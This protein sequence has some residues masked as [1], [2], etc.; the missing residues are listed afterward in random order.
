MKA[1][2]AP[3]KPDHRFCHVSVSLSVV[4]RTL[5]LISRMSTKPFSCLPATKSQIKLN[6]T[7]ETLGHTKYLSVRLKSPVRSLKR[8][9]EE[10]TIF[11]KLKPKRTIV[12]CRYFQS[13][14]AY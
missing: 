9:V 7:T 11:S 8:D 10:C 3:S 1:K 4:A 2:G 12:L 14:Y 6:D 13:I 5:S